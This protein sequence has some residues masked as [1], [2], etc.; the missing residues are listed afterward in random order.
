MPLK[1]RCTE[2]PMRNFTSTIVSLFTSFDI[3]AIFKFVSNFQWQILVA[4]FHPRPYQLYLFHE[5]VL[6]HSQTGNPG[7][8]RGKLNAR[9][10]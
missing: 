3:T 9:T 7:H 5:D 1:D 6:L 8:I 10:T 4:I 2:P